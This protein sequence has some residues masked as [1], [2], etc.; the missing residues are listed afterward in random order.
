ME[1]L[2]IEGNTEWIVYCSL[3]MRKPGSENK[4]FRM[5]V[6]PLAHK[7]ILMSAEKRK[8]GKEQC[9]ARRVCEIKRTENFKRWKMITWS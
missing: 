8:G 9:T 6:L 5:H 1:V 3:Q 7:V 2:L 4:T